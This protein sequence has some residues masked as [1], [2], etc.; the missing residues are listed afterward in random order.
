MIWR[1][2]EQSDLPRAKVT[3]TNPNRT[4]RTSHFQ[5]DHWAAIIEPYL[6]VLHGW[7]IKRPDSFCLI[8]SF[9]SAFLLPNNFIA[10]LLS[11]IGRTKEWSTDAESEKGLSSD[12]KV[13]RAPRFGCAWKTAVWF[14][15]FRAPFPLW[16]FRTERCH[17]CHHSRS[18][19]WSPWWWWSPLAETYMKVGLCNSFLV[20]CSHSRIRCPPPH[21]FLIA[22]AFDSSLKA[23]RFLRYW[24]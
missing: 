7:M 13:E 21:Q 12:R 8:L 6:N 15:S 19:R 2:E 17:L 24:L 18:F 14:R 23:F 22:F 11:A 4:C 5:L 9:I 20:W 1:P 16:A 3:C 10:S